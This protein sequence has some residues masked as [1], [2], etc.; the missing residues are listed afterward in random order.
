MC[1]YCTR[2]RGDWRAW[3]SR[4][5]SFL[6]WIAEHKVAVVAFLAKAPAALAAAL[7]ASH[8]PP[9]TNHRSPTAS[10]PRAMHHHLRRRPLR[11]S[12][13]DRRHRGTSSRSS[14]AF[15]GDVHDELTDDAEAVLASR[16]G[17]LALRAAGVGADVS[18]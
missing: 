1:T 6:A 7:A 15:R 10:S 12:L 5:D 14:S 16:A 9:Y 18:H 17:L 13:Y 3:A 8:L 2:R 11:F 4:S